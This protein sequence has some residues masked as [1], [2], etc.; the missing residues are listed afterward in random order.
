MERPNVQEAFL[1][2][3]V[4]YLC[5]CGFLKPIYRV[6]FC[7]HCQKIRC[8]NCVSQ[9]M[10]ST[11][12]S[13]CLEMM[14]NVEAGLKKNRCSTCKDCPSCGHT[15]STRA[16]SIQAPSM[17]DPTKIVPRKVYYVACGFCR[18]TSRDSKLPDQ[19]VASG[20]WTEFENP[21]SERLTTLSDNY[22][23]LAVLERSAA[24]QG[25]YGRQDKTRRFLEGKGKFG[26]MARATRKQAGLP[27]SRSL[28]TAKDLDAKSL[29]E[30]A[31]EPFD[32][33]DDALP[34][35]A[36][37]EPLVLTS[38]TTL[39]QRLAFPELQTE[40]QDRLQP[41]H[42][43]AEMKR[44]MRCRYCDHNL[45]KPEYS[46]ISIK[47]RIQLNAYYHVPDVKI[48]SVGELLVG[49][50][51]ETVLTFSNPTI[52]PMTIRLEKYREP[53]E[54]ELQ[55]NPDPEHKESSLLRPVTLQRV[56]PDIQQTAELTLPVAEVVLAPRDDSAEFDDAP[57]SSEFRD[58]PSVV[59]WR[60]ANKVALR[61]PVT[62]LPS[63]AGGRCSAALLLHYS[64]TN[65]I[66][67]GENK[68]P[69]T[70]KLR[71]RLVVDLGEITAA[72]GSG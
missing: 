19:N 16:T 37:T 72:E 68:Q 10:D 47:F 5:S 14:S 63:A 52:Y 69:Q 3:R 49:Q 40:R 53:D 17:E 50:Q 44:S 66:V 54:E 21:D 67:T 24:E 25:K 56:E 70:L 41:Q 43:H 35:S 27:P 57:S 22:R 29:K 51:T 30:M 11:Y 64:Y 23:A 42:K 31:A 2:E 8:G 6:Y 15:L 48:L 62:P 33:A 58:D 65:T 46:C 71:A 34:E 13:G 36:F 55:E 26:A 4:K 12:C 61:V 59:V 60:Q 20:T 1:S 28:V 7:R 9:E 32:E 18:W 45:S 39:D 38:V